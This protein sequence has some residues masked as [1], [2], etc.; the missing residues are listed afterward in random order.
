[1]NTSQSM[2]INKPSYKNC[3]IF[4]LG[5]GRCGTH[6]MYELFNEMNGFSAH[7]IL[8]L[9]ADSF[10]RY[11]KWNNLNIDLGGLISVREEK[12]IS[13]QNHNTVYMEA[14]PYLSFHVDEL[15]KHFNA[16]FIFIIRNP[17]DVINSH[18][19][20]GW[21]ENRLDRIDSNKPIGFQYKMNTN[22]FFGR[23]IPSQAEFQRWSGLTRIGKLSWMWDNVNT[24]LHHD[25]AKIPDKNK[26]FL[27]V[28]DLTHVEFHN[29][30]R[31]F[32]LSGD[33]SELCFRNITQRRPGKSPSYMG[34]MKWSNEDQFQ[35][36]SETAN[37]KK[38]FGYDK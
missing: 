8:H 11:A 5:T 27:K 21:Y 7:H 12:M 28:E 33:L 26:Y 30:L 13:A 36:N 24:R 9:D 10:Y 17:K 25:L 20:K 3:P 23:I 29:V 6:L 16:K 1:M 15:Y 37:S 34:S 2:N 19:K 31:H 18:V 35:F 4:V 14:N 38:I 22:H 32:E